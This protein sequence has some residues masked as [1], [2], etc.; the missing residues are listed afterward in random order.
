MMDVGILLSQLGVLKRIL[1]D[2]LNAVVEVPKGNSGS[3]DLIPERC[4]NTVPELNFCLVQMAFCQVQLLG[5]FLKCLDGLFTKCEHLTEAR[6]LTRRVLGFV[7]APGLLVR[8]SSPGL[9]STSLA[10]L[11]PLFDHRSH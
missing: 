7:R 9:V 1:L 10:D 2:R 4:K 3:F 8:P 11:G 5:Q 6:L